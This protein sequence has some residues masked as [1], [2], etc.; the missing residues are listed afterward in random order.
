MKVPSVLQ[1]RNYHLTRRRQIQVH[2]P[3]PV[4]NIRLK[5]IADAIDLPLSANT[6][7][8]Y[9]SERNG[10]GA[11]GGISQFKALAPI[12]RLIHVAHHQRG[13]VV[14]GCDQFECT[15][16]A[17]LCSPKAATSFLSGR[18]VRKAMA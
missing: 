10:A 3:L 5:F 1:R 15:D 13:A 12:R 8:V 6:L 9:E 17:L 16:F 7:R 11:L 2:E 4:R 14:F 18:F